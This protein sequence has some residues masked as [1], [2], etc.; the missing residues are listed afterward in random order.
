ME[1]ELLSQLIKT[2]LTHFDEQNTTYSPEFIVAGNYKDTIPN[3]KISEGKPVFR[4]GANYQLS[5]ATF[6]RA[7]W[8]Q[9]YRYP[10]IAEQFIFTN[11]GGL[12]IFPNPSLKSETGWS[13]EIGVKQGFKI[14]EWNGYVDIAAFWSEYQGMMEFQSVQLGFFAFQSLNIGD[15]RIIGKGHPSPAHQ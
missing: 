11:A 5:Q 6:L 15:T 1:N 9:G 2:A 7:S 4:L 14:G 12:N 3:G 10:T 8:G 13:S